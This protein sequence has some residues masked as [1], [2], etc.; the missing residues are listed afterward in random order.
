VHDV[1]IIINDVKDTFTLGG[2]IFASPTTLLDGDVLKTFDSGWGYAEVPNDS[3]EE[4]QVLITPTDVTGFIGDGV[5]EQVVLDEDG[6]Y[7]TDA[8]GDL[9]YETIDRPD[10]QDWFKIDTV[11][12]LQATLAVEDYSQDITDDL[13]NE[14]TVTNKAT[15]LLYDASG[16]LMDFQYTSNSTEQYQTI[17]LPSTGVHYLAVIA[18]VNN[19]KYTLALAPVEASLSAP[20]ISSKDSYALNQFISYRSFGK[21]FNAELYKDNS[22][23]VFNDGLTKQVESLSNKSN[24]KG[25]KVIEFDYLSEYSAVF[26]SDTILDSSSELMNNK[27]QA[28]YLKHWKLLQHHRNLYP[29]L[30]LDFDFKVKKASFIQDTYYSYQWG[31]QQIGLDQVLNAIGSETKNVAVAVIDSGSPA[32]SSTAWTTSAFLQGGYDFLE[33]S[34]GND[35][36]GPDPDP[37]DT[38]D[39]QNN[40]H[41][42]HVGST[43]AALNDGQNINGFGINVVPLRV[44]GLQGGAYSSDVIAAMLYAA[45]LPNFTNFVYTGSVPIRVIN[46]S[47]GS[48]G[49]G[50]ANSYRNAINDVTNTGITVVAA[51]G[52]EAIEA[53]GAFGYP[54]SC[55]NVISVG[56]VDPNKQ[57]AYY[58]NYN[59]QVDIAAPGGTSG[60]DINGDGQGDGILAFDGSESL[61]IQQGTSMAS[62]HAA[63]AI[64][65]IYS[66]KPEWTPVQM[67]AFIAS[68]YLTDDVGPE[69]KDDDYGYG[70]LNLSKGFT[71]LID[72]G[73]D[74]TYATIT[75]G[76]FGFGYTDTE[77]T[78]TVSKV[79][80]GEL[81]I[82]SI[83]ALDSTL[84]SVT[85]S[86]ID[87][88]GFGTYKVSINRANRPDGSYQSS[89]KAITNDDN[90]INVNF[91]Y[92]VGAERTRPAIGYTLMYLVKESGDVEAAY[93]TQLPEGGVNFYV[94]D[95][96]S[97]VYYWLFSTSID[98]DGYIGGYGEIW[99]Y[100]PERASQYQ[101]FELTDSDVQNSA[102]NMQ[103]R[104]SSGGLSASS[105]DYAKILD[106]D[107][108]LI[109]TRKITIEKIKPIN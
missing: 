21:N 87:S 38:V 22:E 48:L 96:P 93:R 58:S 53:P 57:R 67:E 19:T 50:C 107:P 82:T 35:G 74:F 103:T 28:K 44:F 104:K 86:E 83:E 66:L 43:I 51:S 98:D 62:P 63:G 52:N 34:D 25:L 65:L 36:S 90:Q 73:L 9:Q 12:N 102:V 100:Y 61:A 41:G 76:S 49:N 71:A 60:T 78:I 97:G 85:A 40:S 20:Y 47:L 37:T 88:N 77:K 109:N 70:A 91:S 108:N 16:Q 56:S 29:S 17:N 1:Q 69:G 54:A 42:T 18:D 7:I 24:F 89:V 81:S 79:G 39:V 68:G 26:G 6:N 4:A 84:T 30:D 5:Y 31:L 8:N 11:P 95:I 3:Y 14:T 55:P 33:S 99:E 23:S 2:T 105:K 32:Q 92:S 46:M 106:F 101:Y 59:N 15:L 13:G 94:E 45:K 27:D 10:S 72:G 64:A 80:S 75:P